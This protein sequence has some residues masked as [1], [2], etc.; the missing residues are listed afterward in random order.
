MDMHISSAG[1]RGVGRTC[2]LDGSQSGG[3]GVLALLGGAEGAV[4]AGS[5]DAAQCA[6]TSGRGGGLAM[7]G[8]A[9]YGLGV[10]CYRWCATS[11]ACTPALALLCGI[12]IAGG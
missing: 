5:V 7:A 3:Q 10:G 1:M 4:R 8:I 11:V 12:G 6:T 2:R 9:V